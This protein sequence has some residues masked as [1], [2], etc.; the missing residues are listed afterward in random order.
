MKKQLLLLT[1]LLVTTSLF[2]QKFTLRGIVTDP[3]NKEALVG[4]SVVV[5]GTTTGAVTDLDGAYQL[6][7]AKGNYI[8]VFSYVGYTSSEQTVELNSNNELNAALESSI[9][10]KEVLVTADIATDR[11]TPVAFSNIGTVKLKEELASQDLPMVLNSTPG[12]YAT[13][14]GGGDWCQSNLIFK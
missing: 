6:T 11:K 2:A 7:L 8:L 14:Q 13:Q 5:K 1:I 10:L 9:A 4:A 3:A 12:A